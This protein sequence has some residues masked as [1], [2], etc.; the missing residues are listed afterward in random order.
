MRS[1]EAFWQMKKRAKAAGHFATLIL[2]NVAAIGMGLAFYEQKPD[3]LIGAII[4]AI[5]GCIITWGCENA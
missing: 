5:I 4:A 3:A 1:N 2:A